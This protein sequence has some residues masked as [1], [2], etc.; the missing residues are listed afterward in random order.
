MSS[1]PTQIGLSA[2]EVCELMQF[3]GSS[4]SKIGYNVSDSA[5]ALGVSPDVLAGDL[6]AKPPAEEQPA[7][8]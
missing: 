1:K 4:Q 5:A 7:R 6:P 3:R 8:K 2:N